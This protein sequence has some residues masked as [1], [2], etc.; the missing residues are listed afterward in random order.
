M[1]GLKQDNLP[2]ARRE[3]A[4]MIPIR[5]ILVSGILALAVVQA[6]TAAAAGV[7]LTGT[8]GS[9]SATTTI[10]G[11]QIPPPDPKFGGVI[12]DSAVGSTPFWPPTVVPPKGAP[13]VLLIMTDDQGYGATSTFGGIFPTPTMDRIAKDG[14]RYTQFH[15]TALCSPTRAALITGRNHHSVGFGVIAEQST[16]YPGYDSIIEKNSATIGEILKENGYA[17]SWFGK[18]HNTPTYLYS[19][20]GPFDQWP[21]GMGF[22]YFY[23][24]MGG[25]TNQWTPYLFRDHTQIFPWVGKP[26]YNLITDM[27]DEAIGYMKE[28]NAAAPDKPFFLY[29]V[30][31][32]THAPHHPTPEWIAKMKGKF[33]MGWNELREQ[34]FA[35]QKKLGVIPENT[36]LTPWPD[37]LPK[38]DTLKPDEKKVFAHQ[39]E[40]FA[41]Y[42]AY[43]DYEIGRVVQAVED[44]GKLDNTLI[45]YI[46]GDNGTSAEGTAIGTTFDLAAIQAID[47]PVEA[48]LKY[49]DVLGSDQTTP[50][51]SVAW[52]WAFDT[53]F[54]WTKQ[55]ASYF[56]GT[57]QGMAISWPGHIKD[58]GGVRSQFHHIIDIVPTILEAANIQAP[59]VVDGIEQKPIEGVSMAYTFDAANAK[60]PSH[61]DSQYFEMFGNR[62]MYRDGW[63][64]TTVPPQPPWLMGSVQMPDV[65]NGY[66]WELYNINEDFSENNDLAAQNPAKLK[67]LQDLFMVEAKKYDVLPLDNSILQRI[68]T[69]RPSAV[70]GRTEFTYTGEISG[71][72]DGSVPNT[73]SK[74]Y[75]ITAEVEI[76][77]GG[78]EGM[79]NTL[80]GRFGGYALYLLK[81]KPVFTYNLL[82]LERFRWEGAQ[83]LTPGKHTV[84]FDFQ[85]DGPGFA[86]GGTGVLSVDGKEVATRTIPH[87]IPVLMTIDETFDVGV[88]TR[89][90]VDDK[91]YQSPF[92]FTG[93]LDKL[94]IKLVPP[95][96]TAEEEKLLQQKTAEAKAA[97]Q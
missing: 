90:G 70:A 41:A 92:R 8:L 40:V 27:A 29:Y 33:D 9:P 64:A 89:T 60:A 81:G 95:K 45:I 62:A 85:Y 71:L 48:Q 83:A 54:K 28:L 53:P 79:L 10:D 30:P 57:R 93:T 51:M 91:D 86:K 20:A 68:L 23:G 94:T 87:T 80:G 76:P 4:T 73:L 58:V 56:G 2:V 38:W 26:G 39:A 42:V 97:A 35:N 44:L 14:L 3:G 66:K 5:S 25:E 43:T 77:K 61:R 96:L 69:P 82:A 24:F 72:P 13:N 18:N 75:S 16:G 46:S 1:T 34:I 12:K 21:S 50:H 15:S 78:A 31:G 65:I 67:E 59:T 7:E 37:S 32:G 11:K 52:S 55:V 84:S 36:Q 19:K 63:I 88:D 22:Q 17:T 49:Y 47:M 6:T 74:S